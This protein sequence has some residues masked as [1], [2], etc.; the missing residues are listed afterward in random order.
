MP[1][2]IFDGG[3]EEGSLETSESERGNG[4]DTPPDDV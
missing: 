2:S 3:V 1:K 4:K